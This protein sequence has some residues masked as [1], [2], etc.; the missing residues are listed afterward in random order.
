[1]PGGG[2]AS[3]LA[4]ALGAALS[5]MVSNLM[6]G[7]KKYA[8]MQEQVIVLLEKTAR[9]RD[10]FLLLA[11]EDAKA[12]FPLSQAYSLLQDDDGQKKHREAVMEKALLDASAVPL[13]IM[14]KACACIDVLEQ[15][16]GI[17]PKL[18]I[19]DVGV[20]VQLCR[21][22]LLGASMNVFINTKL[23]KDRREAGKFNEQANG[24]IES[25]IKKADAVYGSVLKQI[26]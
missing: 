23:M 16:A 2:G 20:G 11:D 15:L 21:A 4:G 8:D 5:G 12:F 18:A 17:G 22:S 6:L 3:A 26:I 10:E 14:E 19:S 9:L 1:V 13:K 25:G 24:L 7:K